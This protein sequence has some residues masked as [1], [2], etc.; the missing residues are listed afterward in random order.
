VKLA[1][2]LLQRPARGDLRDA[3]VD[4]HDGAGPPERDLL[5]ERPDALAK[6]L[7]GRLVA[8]AGS[9]DQVGD[10]VAGG[11]ER[12]VGLRE[13]RVGREDRRRPSRPWW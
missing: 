2:R 5:P 1:P 7:V 9:L 10:A 11:D 3:L 8:W 6:L 12:V 13:V 4:E